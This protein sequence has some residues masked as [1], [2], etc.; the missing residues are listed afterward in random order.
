MI[1]STY[2]TKK[3]MGRGGS[4]NVFMVETHSGDLLAAKVM[5]D[6]KEYSQQY[7][8]SLLRKETEVMKLLANHPNILQTH[9]ILIDTVAQLPNG[10]VENIDCTIL[11]LAENGAL[12]TLCLK[13]KRIEEF[14]ASF[15]MNQLLSALTFMHDWDIAHWDIKPQNIL[16]DRY[17]NV[18]LS[19]FGV[20]QLILS[21]NKLVTKRV[22]TEGFM[23][24]EL[25]PLPRVDEYD[26][27]AS[28]IYALG[29]TLLYITCGVRSFQK[30]FSEN[31]TTSSGDICQK[32]NQDLDYLLKEVEISHEL[33][34]L[35][36][37][38]LSPCPEL[39]PSAEE[40]LLHPWVQES[41]K[42][43]PSEVYEYLSGL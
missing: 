32:E 24:P 43:H 12:S 25:E 19:D 30:L 18:K 36:T 9:E 37:H 8:Q 3:L 21:E 1:N 33:R 4:A 17:F 2:V 40:I 22:G 14:A 42:I 15:I 29:A 28:D 5:K 7:S 11:E 10:E 26:P 39:R 34:D 31:S 41:V 13:A 35:L 27:K 20:S 23:A 38:M 6:K 16:L